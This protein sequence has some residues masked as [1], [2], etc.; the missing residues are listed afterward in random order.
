MRSTQPFTTRK[1]GSNPGKFAC[2]KTDLV[3]RLAVIVAYFRHLKAKRFHKTFTIVN[4]VV[5]YLLSVCRQ[6]DFHRKEKTTTVRTMDHGP[7]TALIKV[8]MM[9]KDLLDAA[10]GE[11]LVK[12]QEVVR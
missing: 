7:L 3:N 9:V 6:I 8:K 12:A 1:S 4:S 10:Q 2:P 11:A 5:S